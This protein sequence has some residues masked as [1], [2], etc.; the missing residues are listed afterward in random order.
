VAEAIECGAGGGL[1][2]SGGFAESGARGAALEAE[3]R[4]LCAGC[5]FRLLGPNTAGF[6]NKQ[7]SLTASFL[8]GAAG[9]RAGTVAVVAQSAGINLTVSFLLERLGSGVAMAVGLGN[10][11][12]VDAAAVLDYLVEL[13]GVKSI[14]L[15]LEGVDRGRTLYET[16][17]RVTPRK[18][19]AVLTVGRADVGEFALS[20][21][22]K[23]IGS[24]SRRVDA[25]RQAGAVVVES[26]EELAA[27]AA[28]LSRHRLPPKLDAG[29]GLLT[30]QAGP[31]LVMLDRLRTRGISVPTL[32]ETTLEHIRQ[33]L[34]ALT[35]LENP[36][37]T[38]RP[39][40][41]FAEVLGHLA[42]DPG[43]DLVMAYALHEPAALRPEEAL[44]AVARRIEKPLL[45]GTTGPTAETAVSVEALRNHGVYVAESPEKLAQA[46]IVLCVD[47]ALRARAERKDAAVLLEHDVELPRTHDEHEAKRLLE[48]I[49]IPAPR[50]AVCSSHDQARDALRRLA[51]PVVAKILAPE[52]AHKTEL[53]GVQLKLATEEQLATALARLDAIPVTGERRY[54]IEEMAPPGL[55]LIVGAVRDPSFGPTLLVGAGGTLAELLKDTTTRLAPLSSF[56]A[57]AMLDELGVAPLFAGFRGSPPLDRRAV[58]NAIANLGAL[59]AA[60]PELREIEINPLRVYERGVMALDAVVRYTADHLARS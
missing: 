58:A 31:G 44:P 20:H 35:Y 3:L 8:P 39:G 57:D 59:L 11:T 38:G 23:L 2:L 50:R 26:A 1:V 25:L 43:I 12:D 45:F 49:G 48:L 22:G 42:G 16:L 7:V 51:R 33:A 29:V 17:R 56:D 60:K 37:D 47:A 15:H 24:Y 19:V 41:S 30:A 40:P 34:P 21:T 53:G 46:A 6:V 55:E 36:V 14:A 9:L 52:I 13:P 32:A 18:P 54:L 27:A 28:V 4:A 10:A 5:S